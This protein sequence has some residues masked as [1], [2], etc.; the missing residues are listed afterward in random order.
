MQVANQHNMSANPRK[1][2]LIY[3]KHG[4]WKLLTQVIAGSY[5]VLFFNLSM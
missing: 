3:V 2:S 1:N 5:G 4:L